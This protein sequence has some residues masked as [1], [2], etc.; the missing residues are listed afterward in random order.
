MTVVQKKIC[1]LGEF[2]VGKTSLVRRFV[3]GR[4]SD[5][6]LST[7]GVNIKRKKLDRGDHTLVF[8]LWDLA[9]GNN[10]SQMPSSYLRGASGAIIVCDLTRESTLSG[11]QRYQT[12]LH[13]ASPG[14]EIV[15]AANKLDLE[16]EREIDEQALAEVAER[17][18]APIFTTSA[19]SGD[20]VE[21]AFARLAD[22]LEKA[23]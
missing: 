11:L 13:E 12:Q 1:L 14:A 3:D 8:L 19:K 6:Y 23:L 7:I 2:A 4:F 18:G 21:A 15:L 5:K 16:A 10:Y 20:N 22:L 17:L 9:G